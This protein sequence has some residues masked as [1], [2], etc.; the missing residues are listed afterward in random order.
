MAVTLD[1]TSK[2]AMLQNDSFLPMS[3]ATSQ[4]NLSRMTTATITIRPAYADDQLAIQRLAA[5]D[6][7]DLP[8]EPPLLVAEVDGELRVAL[9]LDNGSAIADPF[10]PT[11]SL[12]ALM[13]HHMKDLKPAP[14]RRPRA[15]VRTWRRGRRSLDGLQ[16]AGASSV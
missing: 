15:R 11:A 14:Q 6:S 2:A 7:A 1:P 4:F 16:G 9:S 8:P 5:L 3:T 12:V 13:R 10:F